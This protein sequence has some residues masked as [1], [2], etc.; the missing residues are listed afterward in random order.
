LG[1]GIIPVLTE[2]PL[3]KGEPIRLSFTHRILSP[4]RR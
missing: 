3:S 4:A 1:Y 2:L